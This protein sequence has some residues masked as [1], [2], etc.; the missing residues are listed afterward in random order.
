MLLFFIGVLFDD[1][2]V[3]LAVAQ[4]AGFFHGTE[5]Q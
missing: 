1:L 5:R 2:Q 3:A 4:R